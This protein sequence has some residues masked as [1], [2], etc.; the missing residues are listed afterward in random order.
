MLKTGFKV[1]ALVI[2]RWN[3]RIQAMPNAG[4]IECIWFDAKQFNCEQKLTLDVGAQ[5]ATLTTRGTQTSPLLVSSPGRMPPPSRAVSH[6]SEVCT[7]SQ[8]TFTMEP[9]LGAEVRLV[10]LGNLTWQLEHEVTPM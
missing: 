3:Q 6:Y 1:L 9:L 2:S 5:T 4:G 7:H 8:C 10:V